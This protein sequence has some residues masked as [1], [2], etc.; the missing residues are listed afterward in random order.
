MTGIRST[1][2]CA[3]P[4][5]RWGKPGHGWGTPSGQIT[6]MKN[7]L[8]NLGFFALL[9]TLSAGPAAAQRFGVSAGYTRTTGQFGDELSNEGVSVRVGAELNPRSIVRFGV[10]AGMDRLNENRQFNQGSCLHPAGGTATCYSNSRNRD[11]GWSFAATVRAG[12]NGGTVR[13]Y[14]LAG[15]GVLS[16]RTRSRN[17]T[18]DS[19]GA[20]LSNFE[21]DGTSS[22]GALQAPLGAGVLFRP[23]GSLISIGIEG[24]VTP[25][26]NGYDGGPNFGWSPSV[27]LMVRFGN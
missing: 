3:W 19:T 1:I 18:T 22:D 24:R 10:E 13:P 11:T 7:A 2:S 12:P 4:A 6:G 5:R 23:K 27:A 17:T 15:L 26:L 9:A 16:T 8:R 25:L 21:Y 20:H 14:I